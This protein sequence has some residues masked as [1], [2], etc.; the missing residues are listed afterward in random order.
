MKTRTTIFL[1]LAG[2]IGLQAQTVITGG[3][4]YGEW[5]TEE[6]PF[7]IQG[8]IYLPPDQRLTIR[9]GVEV[10][11]QDYYSFDIEF[12]SKLESNK[13]N[14]IIYNLCLKSLRPQYFQISTKILFKI[15]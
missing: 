14:K 2:F 4:V 6:S 1:I 9:P 5:K 3:D 15:S 7:L 13:F 10:V 12:Y 8:D 11:F